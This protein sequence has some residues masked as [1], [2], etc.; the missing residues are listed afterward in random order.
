V[1]LA[2]PAEI[3]HKKRAIGVLATPP[4][5]LTNR[6]GKHRMADTIDSAP[7]H[8]LDSAEE[9]RAVP[10]FEGLYEVSDQGRVRSLDRTIE[11]IGRWGG[12][13]AKRHRGRILKPASGEGGH[14]WVG[15]GRDHRD[16]VHRLVLTAFVRD[17]RDDEESRHLD[18]NPANNRLENLAW[19]TRLENMA[20]RKRLGE[21][22][23]PRGTRCRRAKFTEDDVYFIRR[24]VNRGRS[25]AQI[26]RVLGA[27]R[28]AVGKVAMGYTWGWLE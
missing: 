6:W 16:F 20:D 23:P 26:A 9:W 27:S 10:G 13:V 28:G 14:L 17:R 8:D 7:A 3:C 15:L 21:E 4:M 2:F 18:G 22:N 24:E 11:C 1:R 12:L 5:A 19:G 25:F